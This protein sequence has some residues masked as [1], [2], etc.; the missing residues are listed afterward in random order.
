MRHHKNGNV[1]N[2]WSWSHGMNILVHM[3]TLYL[4][5]FWK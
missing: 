1:K 2:V 4:R 3:E 5:T